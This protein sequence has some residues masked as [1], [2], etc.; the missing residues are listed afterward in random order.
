MN[1][2][3]WGVKAAATSTSSLPASSVSFLFLT[4]IFSTVPVATEKASSSTGL[5]SLLRIALPSGP[6]ILTQFLRLRP[7]PPVTST[8]VA[9]I[10]EMP[11][12]PAT[13]GA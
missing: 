13:T 9:K 3:F 7:M 12:V 5:P 6:V 2:I 11:L 10:G 4:S 8:V 1:S